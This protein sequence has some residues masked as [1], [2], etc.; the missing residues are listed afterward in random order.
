MNPEIH[1]IVEDMKKYSHKT[2]L[3]SSDIQNYLTI[4]NARLLVLLAE[5]TETQ[6]EKISNQG[7][8]MIGL[9]KAVT[10]FTVLLLI[11]GALQIYYMI[12][13]P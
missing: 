11:I 3:G 1:S 4:Q 10:G 9:T 6:S 8:I 7:N 13:K 5:E 2:P 12:M